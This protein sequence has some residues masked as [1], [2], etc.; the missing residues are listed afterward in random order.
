M[1]GRHLPPAIF[2]DPDLRKEENTSPVISADQ[3]V[4]FQGA[5]HYGQVTADANIPAIILVRR[6]LHLCGPQ[7]IL[8]VSLFVT[9]PAA[10]QPASDQEIVSKYPLQGGAVPP[11]RSL[12]PV[13]CQP[14][15]FLLNY[16]ISHGFVSVSEASGSA[17]SG[18]DSERLF[19]TVADDSERDRV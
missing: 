12:N 11:S 1:T 6:S 8:D 17:P 16:R 10:W 3:G 14:D 19:L 2:S 7:T 15:N 13:V 18:F 9:E 5:V 4:N